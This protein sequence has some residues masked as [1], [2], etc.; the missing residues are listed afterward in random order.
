MLART[1]TLLD[2]SPSRSQSTTGSVIHDIISYT[3]F[4]CLLVY[5]HQILGFLKVGLFLSVSFLSLLTQN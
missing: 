4:N 3:V 1:C 5:L 2:A